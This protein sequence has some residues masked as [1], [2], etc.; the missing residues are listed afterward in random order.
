GLSG[1]LRGLGFA[2]LLDGLARLGNRGGLRKLCRSALRRHHRL[3]RRGGL[4]LCR[5][6]RSRSR[7]FSLPLS[8]R[9]HASRRRRNGRSLGS[10][11]PLCRRRWWWRRRWRSQR[12]QKLQ[13][14]RPRSQLAIQQQHEHIVRD[15]RIRRHL[16]RDAEFRHL[17][18]RN[19]LLHL[20][21][22]GEEIL[23]LLHHRLLPR[24]NRQKQNHLRTRRRQQLPRPRRCSRFLSHQALGQAVGVRIQILPGLN[25]ILARNRPPQIRNVLVAQPLGEEMQHQRR[26]FRSIA[27]VVHLLPGFHQ[28]A[29]TGRVHFGRAPARIQHFQPSLFFISLQNPLRIVLV[30]QLLDLVSDARTPDVFDVVVFLARFVTRLCPFLERPVKASSKARGADHPRRI[31]K[32]R[33]VMQHADYFRFDVGHTV[34]R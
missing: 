3:R 23:D 5:G 30:R 34:E 8:A 16:W 19:L 11:T 26:N 14:L 1:R 25:Q 33:V 15:L 27:K 2:R 12:L 9:L 6:C 4:H 17:R 29:Q 24:R 18:Q 28:R 10:S 22:L 31:L 32:K 21:P 20:P 13:R 7:N